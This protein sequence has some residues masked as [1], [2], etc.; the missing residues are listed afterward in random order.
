MTNRILC[1]DSIKKFRFYRLLFFA[2]GVLVA[3]PA[4]DQTSANSGS[5]EHV[6]PLVADGEGFRSQFFLG[7]AS[8]AVNQCS[9]ELVGTG[10]DMA[11]FESH[12]AVAPNGAFATIDL[13]APNA[14]VSFA[15]LGGGAFATGYAKFSCAG[16]AVARLLLSSEAGGTPVSLATIE[17]A[18]SGAD[19]A[20][21]VPSSPGSLGLAL[22]NDGY[23][24]ASCG[25]VLQDHSAN[26]FAQGA[27]RIPPQSSGIRFLDDI[28]RIPTGF[29]GGSVAV[30]C[31]PNVY[32]LGRPAGG[33]LFSALP[34]ASRSNKEASRYADSTSGV[35]TTATSGD[36]GDSQSTATA[37]DIPSTTAG[38]LD[39]GDRDYFRVELDQAGSFTAETTGS[40]DTYGWVESENGFV[41]DWSDDD[42]EGTNFRIVTGTLEA[43]TYY[44]VVEGY[45]PSTL[46]NYNLVLTGEGSALP[47]AE[48]PSVSIDAIAAGDEDTTVRLGATLAGGTWDG[49][50]EY[51]WSVSGGRLDNRNSATPTWIRPSVTADANHTVRL[52]VFVQGTGTVARNGSS[53]LANASRTALVRNTTAA[54]PVAVAPTVSINR[55]DAGD[56]GA[57]VQLGATLTG[58]THDGSPEYAWTA[59]GGSFDDPSSATP[60]WTRPSVNADAGHAVYLTVTVRGTGTVARANTSDT[61]NSTRYNI[62]RNVS[63]QLPA[64]SAPTTLTVNAIADGDEGATVQ[65]FST[66]TGGVYDRLEYAW[67]VSGGTLSDPAAAFPVW[68]RPP[69]TADASH[70]VELTVTT[71]GTGT[72][73]RAGSSETATA[74][75]TALVRNVA[76]GG[77]GNG[78]GNTGEDDHGN[79]RDSATTVAI[80]STTD[81]NLTRGDR[82]YFRIDIAQ[83]G[84]LLLET[85]GSR[86]TYGTLFDDAGRR[87][88]QNDDGGEGYNFR[89]GTGWLAAGAYYLEVRGYSVN[90]T[91]DYSLSV[92]GSAR[93]SVGLPEAVPPAIEVR[94]IADGDEDTQAQLGVTLTGGTYDGVPEYNWTVSEGALDNPASAAPVWTRPSV[95]ADTNYTVTLSVTVRGTGTNARDGSSVTL[96]TRR[97][98]LV[99]D[100]PASPPLPVAAAPSVSINAIAAGDENTTVQ[101]GATLAG[102]T[103]DGAIEYAWQVNG[104]ALDDATLAT[105]TWT[106]PSVNSNASYTISLNVTVRGAGTIARTGTSDTANASRSALVQVR[107]T[108]SCVDDAKWK[109]VADYYD[110]NATKAPNYGANW[111]R[112]LIAY[113]GEDP[114]RTLPAWE[115]STARPSTPYTA[116]EATRGEAL[117]FG[118]TPVR[119][120]LDCLED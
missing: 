56:E 68:T 32:A 115:G 76:G 42:G 69:V 55:I 1:H 90:T 15:S 61:A 67:T 51:D 25:I 9:M 46:G 65:L 2:L 47:G 112:V 28:V 24:T 19:F 118:W 108:A 75:G 26:P 13:S 39:T 104:G 95:D 18:P 92:A 88:E 5:L 7:N 73:A 58:G 27:W 52:T 10:F 41:L 71:R 94:P 106:R 116:G 113:Q 8:G 16:P 60:T 53:D 14:V 87:L 78:N 100:V 22:A 102:G 120:V 91:G 48:A 62:V 30:S 119:R 110:V 29:S 114:E 40:I 17:S 36:H 72:R 103:H 66:L 3:L 54:L 57:A 63:A 21:P 34:V 85:T 99:R 82:D 97:F 38:R 59:S 74:N 64:A 23:A 101:L 109:T 31:D 81:G 43:G 70:T 49:A 89:I 77:I 86:D 111:Y 12:V 37:V 33:G 79:G 44:V 11:R 50:V 80:P 98:P 107:D 105:P 6:I 117:W 93:S 83:A 20:L 4:H 96:S 84:T 35:L 45:S